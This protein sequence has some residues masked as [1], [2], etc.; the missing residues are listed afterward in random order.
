MNRKFF[1]A[2]AM[3]C[4]ILA[5]V[6]TACSENDGELSE[7]PDWQ[8]RNVEYFDSIYK[9]ALENSDGKWD[10][11]RA[12]SLNE[13]ADRLAP[14]DYVV[15]H[16]EETGTGSGCPVYTDSVVVHNLGK[17]LPSTNYPKGYVIEKSYEGDFDDY[18]PLT[19]HAKKWYVGGLIDGYTTALMKMH[20]GDRWRVYVPYT[21]AYGTADYNSIPGY[22]VLVWDIKLLGYYH[23]GEK[24]PDMEA[25]SNGQGLW[26]MR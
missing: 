8:R 12:W 16:K 22:S 20:V 15:V 3:L 21:L 6:M 18:N 2:F 25:K 13:N 1:I 23:P 5:G 10:T 4:G 26:N 24:V 9:V 14:S 19:A 11:I 7:Y 17:L